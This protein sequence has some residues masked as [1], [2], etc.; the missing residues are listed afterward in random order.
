MLAPLHAL[1]P[2][3]AARRVRSLHLVRPD[4]AELDVGLAEFYCV[5]PDCECERVFLRATAPDGRLLA[6]ITWAFRDD[7]PELDPLHPQDATA[8]EVLNSVRTV[9]FT[10]S[11]RRRLVGHYRLVKEA[12][13][14]SRALWLAQGT[15][16]RRGPKVGRNERCPC[17]SGRKF[18]RC[19]LG[20]Q[21]DSAGP[22]ERDPHAFARA[23]GLR[24]R[25]VF[26]D[27]GPENEF[28]FGD[29][30]YDEVG[31]FDDD[32]DDGLL[33]RLRDA[34]D[35]EL[36]A[37]VDDG[38]RVRSARQLEP[39]GARPNDAG[40]RSYRL[41]PT[42]VLLHRLAF[43]GVETTEAEFIDCAR[44]VQASGGWAAWEI[45]EGWVG[46]VD[47][48]E[49]TLTAAALWERLLPDSPC[50]EQV[51]ELVNEGLEATVRDGDAW[52][53]EL[54][55]RAW[56]ML[57]PQIE[58]QDTDAADEQLPASLGLSDWLFAWA[59]LF[60]ETEDPELRALPRV[61]ELFAELRAVFGAEQ[62]EM[63]AEFAHAEAYG[64]AAS[65]RGD[66]AEVVWT[67]LIGRRSGAGYLGL[68]EYLVGQAG[69]RGDDALLARAGQILEE[70]ERSVPEDDWWLEAIAEARELLAEQTGEALRV[71]SD[72][73]PI[74]P[75]TSMAGALA[76]ST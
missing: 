54:W 41:T 9:A 75:G 37:L 64:L 67:A 47:H 26:G 46:Q 32:D 14:F 42:E 6:G 18:K 66:E 23:A 17:G 20:S 44:A 1:F 28:G 4:H 7:E 59:E 29:L 65:G 56:T 22:V 62:D 57:R 70:G 2:E 27:L 13:E 33:G 43:A 5:D 40:P 30:F 38:G 31:L 35:A 55:L 39:E 51:D 25:A 73:L 16:V 72:D 63:L 19:C 52:A 53:H 58:A 21:D 48:T 11:Y 68:A 74:G 34:A 76:A 61:A 71:A 8:Q 36:L 24:W 50:F 3:T 49:A 69:A 12:C 45:A 15:T 10:R 60:T